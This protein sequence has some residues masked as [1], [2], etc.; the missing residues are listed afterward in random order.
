MRLYKIFI[1][2]FLICTWAMQ[3]LPA[4]AACGHCPGDQQSSSSSTASSEA[5]TVPTTQST[6]GL[7]NPSQ[8]LPGD[9]PPTATL[10]ADTG[11]TSADVSKAIENIYNQSPGPAG[12]ENLAPQQARDN[13]GIDEKVDTDGN[14]TK[15]YTDSKDRVTRV[16]KIDNTNRRT[17]TDLDPDTGN[18]RS[19]LITYANGHLQRDTKWDPRTKEKISE[20]DYHEDGTVRSHKTW[21][22]D[23]GSHTEN[24][25][26]DGSSII[27]DAFP[28]GGTNA[29]HYRPDGS[30]ESTRENRGLERS[31]KTYNENGVITGE[32]RISQGMTTSKTTY[33]ESG[34][35]NTKFYPDGSVKSQTKTTAKGETTADYPAGKYFESDGNIKQIP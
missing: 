33:G 13:R 11:L 5:A 2:S 24:R 19:E 21:N 8:T 4:H 7:D 26:L 20:I 29:S 6:T 30:L 16:E 9:T 31:V 28:G 14:T 1:L 22:P 3:G 23:G 18:K 32:E 34:A 17:T 10:G 35:T 12:D 25:N 27:V 15:T